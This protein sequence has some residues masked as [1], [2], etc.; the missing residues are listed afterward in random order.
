MMK[1]LESDFL[2]APSLWDVF[3][4]TVVEGMEAGLPVIC[5]K[6]A[7]A[8]MLIEHGGNGFLFDPEKPENLADCLKLVAGMTASERIEM[9]QRAQDSVKA[10]LN[11]ERILT[12]LVESYSDVMKCSNPPRIDPWAA[13]LFSPSFKQDPKPKPGFARRVMRKVV[14][15]F[16]AL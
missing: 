8:E 7:G 16:N 13:S 6:A 1:I 12:L 14:K 15:F 9:G 4:L 11:K 3:N 5:S 2:I 10:L